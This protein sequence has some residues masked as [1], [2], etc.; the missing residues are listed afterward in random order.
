MASSV[1]VRPG[2]QMGML[3]KL[4]MLF[5]SE[6]DPSGPRRGR[7][8]IGDRFEIVSE[9]TS[10]GSMSRVYKAHDRELGRSVCLKIQD[11]DKNSAAAARAH[12]EKPSEGRVSKSI[13][14]P[15]V[16]HT[17]EYGETL[18]GEQYIVMEYVDGVDLKFVRDNVKLNLKGKLKLLIQAAEGLAGVHAAG[19]IHHDMNPGNMMINR[20]NQVKI[21]D[22]GLAVPNTLEFRKPGNRT[23][24]LQYMAPELIRREAIDEKIDIFGFGAVAFEF[25]T[26]RLPFGGTSSGGGNQSMAMMLQRLNQEPLDPHEV[27][28]KLTSEL[29]DVLRKTLARRREERWPSM[30]S[31]A[32]ILTTI[33]GS[34]G[35][36]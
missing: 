14:H 35:K 34:I 23:G 20:E 2:R 10:Q 32:K 13:V 6:D 30:E 25:L 33:R 19:F 5:G 3:T 16:V 28:P 12:D 1:G 22:F 24:T 18:K 11:K 26:K 17:F 15:H 8:D 29:C 4:R 21:I 9:T 36:D 7:V 27:N 31:L